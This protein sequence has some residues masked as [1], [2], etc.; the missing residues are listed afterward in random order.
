M[1]SQFYKAKKRRKASVWWF[2]RLKADELKDWVESLEVSYSVPFRVV[3]DTRHQTKR[4]T[5]RWT[6][7]DIVDILG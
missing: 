2:W 6:K 1:W 3:A 7:A 5:L 4:C